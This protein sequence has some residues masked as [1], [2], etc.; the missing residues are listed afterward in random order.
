VFDGGIV[1]NV[2][3]SNL[4]IDCRRHDWFWWG[5]GDPFHF[6]IKRRSEVHKNVKFENEPPAGTIRNVLIEN[7]IAHGKGASVINGH[8]ASWLDGVT[9]DN[10]K[11]FI[12][13]DSIVAYDKAVYALTFQ[14]AK[15][16]RL[17]NVEVFWGSPES[18]KWRSALLVEDVNGLEIDGF[19]GRQAKTDSDT[20]AIE[21]NR[22][23]RAVIRNSRAADETSTFLGVSG[24]NSRDILLTGND[25][26][27]AKKVTVLKSEVSKDAVQMLNNLPGTR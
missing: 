14:M 22:V 20:P 3:I 6:N 11:L 12:A 25:L 8:P 9:F 10:V 18:K 19:S 5:D 17:R 13:S 27:N 24:K 4:T 1:E 23:E 16:L 26:R 21:F 7:V 2:V 15:N